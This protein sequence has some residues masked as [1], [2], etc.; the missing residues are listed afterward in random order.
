MCNFEQ[1]IDFV[2]IDLPEPEYLDVFRLHGVDIDDCPNMPSR[3]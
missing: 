2:D 1:R 3:I